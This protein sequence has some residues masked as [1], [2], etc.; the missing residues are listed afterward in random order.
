MATVDL[1]PTTSLRW[2]VNKVKREGFSEV[3]IKVLEQLYIS[4]DESLQEWIEVP[5]AEAES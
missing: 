4:E 1:Y 2:K 3:S 5:M